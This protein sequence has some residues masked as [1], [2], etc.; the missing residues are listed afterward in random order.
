MVRYNKMAASAPQPPPQVPN[1]PPPMHVI[2]KNKSRNYDCYKKQNA[3]GTFMYGFVVRRYVAADGV[4]KAIFVYNNPA[5][6][7]NQ[8][9]HV[10]MNK[11]ELTE[12]DKCAH[13]P[14]QD[15][16]SL[17]NEGGG[18]RKSRSAR[19]YKYKKRTTRRRY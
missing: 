10:K 6:G 16:L 15:K 8:A 19:K 3:D 11:L 7:L 9:D 1:M 12:R 14:Y 4:E 18:K 5:T 13:I 2:M 17:Y